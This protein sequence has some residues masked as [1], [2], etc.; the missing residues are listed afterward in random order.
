MEGCDGSRIDFVTK[1]LNKNGIQRPTHLIK[2]YYELKLENIEEL[3]DDEVNKIK[4]FITESWQ[5]FS[6]V[7]V[8]NITIVINSLKYFRDLID[9]L[10]KAFEMSFC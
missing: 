4:A 5:F 10:K 9:M 6:V 8:C 1:I 7:D 3:S 2:N